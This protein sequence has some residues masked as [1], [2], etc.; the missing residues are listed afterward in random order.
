M[1][2]VYGAG[3]RWMR[4]LVAGGGAFARNQWM[5]LR[6]FLAVLFM[7]VFAGVQPR[8]WPR[9]VR[10]AF[11]RQLLRSGVDSLW[12][13]VV[14][15]VL[16]GISVVVQAH[17]WLGKVGLSQKIGPLLVLI[18]ARELGPLF[19]N[20]VIIVKSGSAMATELGYMK[21]SGQ[22]R[23]LE[24]QGVD[25][26]LYLVMPRVLATGMAAFCLNVFFTT[27]A[28][29]S[30]YGFAELLGQIHVDPVTFLYSVLAAVR[31]A[32]VINVVVKSCV[33]AALT[34]TICVTGGLSAVGSLAAIP[35]ATKDALGRSLAAVF[36]VS[37]LVSVLTYF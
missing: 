18:V 22:V 20:F 10:A 6:Y 35:M 13:I 26:F 21:V 25:P 5:D 19:T 12:F 1:G 11:A 27:G 23:V 36:I 32:D 34:A 2:G 15:A 29:V 16:V 17:L 30:G 33:P 24:A 37:A 8:H 31:P 28:F 4:Q 9:T 14:L 3:V 7:T